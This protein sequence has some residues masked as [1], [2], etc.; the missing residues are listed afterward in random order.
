[1]A[2]SEI[3]LT[4]HLMRR[5][6]FGATRDELEEYVAKGY[7]ATVE[8]LLNTERVPGDLEDEDLFRRFH[9]DYYNLLQIQTC[10]VHWMYRMVN[11]KRPLEE[12]LALFW[13]GVFATSAQK[14]NQP[15]VVYRQIEML[16]RYGLGSFRTLLTEVSKDAA[17]M[18]WLDNKDNHKDAVNENYGRE[19]LE[20]FSMG[21]GNY[22]ED[23]VRECARAFTGW[24]IQN[25][26]WHT[27]RVARD[28]F[29]PYGRIAWQFEYRD[30]D[31]DDTEKTFLGHTGRWNGENILDIVCRQPATARF[32]A[33]RLYNF[34]VADEPQV[35]AWE[36][37]P[38][39]DPEAV[40]TLAKAFISYE[41][42]IR[43]VLR[44]LF[45]SDFFKSATYA[46]VKGPVELAVGTVRLAG[47]HR[48]PDVADVNLREATRLMGQELL[49]PPSV[50][51]WHTGAEWI[52][53]GSLVERVNFAIEQLAD[54]DAPGVRSI[55]NRIRAQGED[56]SPERLVDICLDLVGPLTVSNSTREELVAHAMPAGYIRF[57]SEDEASTSGE[58]IKEMLQLIVGTREYQLV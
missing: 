46:K 11:A 54:I 38:P 17:M 20:L 45:N 44:V 10:Q 33:R 31:H 5:A 21:V 57:G 26:S 50:E 13:H 14:L 6:G 39:R 40:D 51:G 41:Y 52:T 28:A 47:G 1:M 58:R 56:I 55:I 23:D 2:S 8:E 48:F 27:V 43:S 36:T 49:D 42:D 29:W 15:R 24:T 37:V 9:Q 7:E 25:P 4:A 19:L 32:I 34:F 12:K 35:P 30:D 3:A 18:Y 53:T 16:R 22:T